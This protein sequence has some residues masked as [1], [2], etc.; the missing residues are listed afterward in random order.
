[1]RRP[2]R[3]CSGP[4]SAMRC[5]PVVEPLE[6][7]ALFNAAGFVDTITNPLLPFSPGARWLYK[8][9]SDGEVERNTVVVQSYTKRIE[10]VTC[11][12]VLDRVY[13][14]GELTEKTQDFYAQDTAGNVWY[15]GE[16]SREIENG[17]IVSREGS[18]LAGVNGATEG[19]AMHAQPTPGSKPYY[20]EFLAGVAEDQAQDLTLYAHAQTPLNRYVHCLKTLEFSALEKGVSEAKFY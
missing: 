12:V 14:A 15:F 6:P 17:K 8:G 20:E 3:T 1:M 11:T 18:W 5:L 10:G 9:V 7:R 4:A 19:I 2:R 13:V 16:A